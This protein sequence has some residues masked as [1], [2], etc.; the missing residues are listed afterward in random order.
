MSEQIHTAPDDLVAKNGLF[1][2]TGTAFLPNDTM[3][4]AMFVTVLY[5]QAGSPAVKDADTAWYGAAAKW[6][7]DN[8]VSDGTNLTGAITR[9]QFITQL[10]RYTQLQKLGMGRS[11]SYS[12]FKDAAKVDTWADAAMQWAVGSG[13]RYY[14]PIGPIRM[15]VAVPLDRRDGVDDPFQVYVSLGQAF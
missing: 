12:A 2:G 4:R 5:R 6:A 14:T 1:K 8:S 9:E 3:T 7:K 10:Y 15:D 11:E 13:I